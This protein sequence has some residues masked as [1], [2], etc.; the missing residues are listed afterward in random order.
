MII[1]N[2]DE[3]PFTVEVCKTLSGD[4]CVFPF[5]YLGTQHDGCITHDNDGTPWCDI[6]NGQKDNCTSACPVNRM[7]TVQ[8]N[9]NEDHPLL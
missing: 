6:G 4:I 1:I 5:T 9:F 8:C 2:N 7:L 3:Q